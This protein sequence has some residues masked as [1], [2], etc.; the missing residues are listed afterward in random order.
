MYNFI[1]NFLML[2]IV[3]VIG[4][5]LVALV[6][7][8]LYKRGNKQLVNRIVLALV[9]EAEKK[10]GSGTGELKYNAV[11]E[12]LY[13]VLPWI[14]KLLYTKKQ[15]DEMIEGAVEYLKRYLSDGKNLYGY[16]HHYQNN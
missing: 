15:M 6:G 14:L 10:Y 7:L 16:E 9:T 11:V 2:N 5:I 12:R 4:T 8:I 13:E 3:E 1:I